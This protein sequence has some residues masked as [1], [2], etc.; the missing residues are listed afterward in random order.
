M[1]I[2]PVEDVARALAIATDN[3]TTRFAVGPLP[4]VNFLPAR[5]R[6]GPSMAMPWR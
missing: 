1:K 2:L 3:P 5:E 4:P 6:T